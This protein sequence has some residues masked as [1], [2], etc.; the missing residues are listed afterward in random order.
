MRQHYIFAVGTFFVGAAIGVL[1]VLSSSPIVAVLIPLLFGQIA[2]DRGIFLARDD[3]YLKA[4][5]DRLAFVGACVTSLCLG[6]ML[7][8]AITF[9]AR[10]NAG[11]K[12]LQEMIGTDTSLSYQEQTLAFEARAVAEILGADLREQS[13]IASVAIMESRIGH[14]ATSDN[15]AFRAIEEDL[16]ETIAQIAELDQI[17]VSAE[18]EEDSYVEAFNLALGYTQALTTLHEGSDV[19]TM[20]WQQYLSRKL[21]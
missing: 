16:I 13:E 4:G 6:L 5:R 10:A 11:P 7:M 18:Q 15:E 3:I 19:E 2:G 1:T 14:K 17:I 21:E 20:L 9:L 8:G 12:T